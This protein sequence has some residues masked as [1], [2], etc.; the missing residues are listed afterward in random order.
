M[1]QNKKE[2]ER[3]TFEEEK[4][5]CDVSGPKIS[6]KDS[7]PQI[8]ASSA[9]NLIEVQV[10]I[11]MGFSGILIPQLSKPDSDIKIDLE[12]ASIVASIV[13]ISIALGGFFCGP[14]MDKFGRKYG[15]RWLIIRL[16]KF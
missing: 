12:S 4:A 16:K 6:F 15:L 8:L 14:L 2:I 13:T 9:A 5:A 7:I 1:T 11:N 3:L 10:G